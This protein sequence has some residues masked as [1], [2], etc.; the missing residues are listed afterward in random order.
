HSGSPPVF[1]TAMVVAPYFP[2]AGRVLL[3]RRLFGPD[4]IE[5]KYKGPAVLRVKGRE[6]H[7]NGMRWTAWSRRDG[8]G[9]MTS[10][11]CSRTDPASAQLEAGLRVERQRRPLAGQQAVVAGRGDHGGVVGA[12]GGRRPVDA[13]ADAGR[14]P[15]GLSLVRGLVRR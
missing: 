9:G 14:L 6:R 10:A 1:V 5:W 13:Q 12:Q 4:S 3:P 7:G 15:E 2:V 11:R 8:V